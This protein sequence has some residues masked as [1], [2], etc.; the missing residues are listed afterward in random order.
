[1]T[2]DHQ[3]IRWLHLSDLHT[4][5]DLA[6]QKD[7]FRTLLED[8]IPAQL[9]KGFRPELVFIT[10]DVANRGKKDEYEIFLEKFFLPL[11]VLLGEDLSRRTFIIP[12]NHDVDVSEARAIQRHGVLNPDR[13][14]E[15][16]D[17]SETGLKLRRPLFDRFAAYQQAQ[18]HGLLEVQ[19]DTLFQEKGAYTERVSINGLQVGILGINTAWLSGIED[20]SEGDRHQMSPG[21]SIVR[22]GLREI[23][24]CD[25]KFVLGH[26]PVDWY[27]DDEVRHIRTLFGDHKVLYL[28]GHLHRIGVD[29]RVNPSS[30]HLEIQAGATYQA[31]KDSRLPPNSGRLG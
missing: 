11:I 31:R 2:Q 8:H 10:G 18:M 6:E 16:L 14:P 24:E 12:G 4:G 27:L 17:Q 5:K 7:Q 15:F 19:H 30:L 29:Y 28:H 26:H 25:V 9:N 1:M 3:R 20:G 21:L 22:N 23:K 13:L